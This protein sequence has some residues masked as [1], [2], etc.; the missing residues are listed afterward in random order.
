MAAAGLRHLP[1]LAALVV[2]LGLGSGVQARR[3]GHY[4]H[5]HLQDFGGGDREPQS[6]EGSQPIVMSPQ[7]EAGGIAAAAAG[8]VRACADQAAELQKMPFDRVLETVRPNDD[9]RTALEQ[10]RSAATDASNKLNASCPN[11]VPARLTDRLDTMR[12]SLDA[13]K[14]ALLRLR[15]A[16]VS[17]YAVLSDEQKA[18]LVAREVSQRPQPEADPAP[19]NQAQPV[20]LDCR[21]WPDMLK[22]WPLNRIEGMALSDE[23]HAALYALMSAVYRAAAGLAASCP[24]EDALTPVSRLDNELGR[25]DALR[26]CIDAIAPALTGLVNALNDAQNAQLNAILGMWQQSQPETTTR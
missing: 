3:S 4:H 24:D 7:P 18:R 10:I 17:A 25:I 5:H 13:M 8:T 23:Q 19:N 16:F 21:Q 1:L 20:A 22:S 26:R 11:D 14:A 9:Q 2:V 6:R 15:P 12:A